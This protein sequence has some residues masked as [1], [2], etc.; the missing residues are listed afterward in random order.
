MAIYLGCVV[1]GAFG[2]NQAQVGD[3]NISPGLRSFSS[4]P[5]G[6][7][8]SGIDLWSLFRFKIFLCLFIFRNSDKLLKL[9]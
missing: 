7:G 1:H 2:L 8:R 3:R 6:L 9:S 4:A 5:H